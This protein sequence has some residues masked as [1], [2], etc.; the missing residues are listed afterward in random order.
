MATI[1]CLLAL[2][3]S[4][5]ASPRPLR[6]Q[7]GVNIHFTGAPERD[8]DLIAEA[9]FG[10]VR[11]DLFWQRIE[12]S[13]GEYRFEPYDQL[14]DGLD[15]RGIRAMMILDYSNPLY[16]EGHSVRTQAGRE[17]F[18]RF[19]AVAAKR[20]RGRGVRWEIWN[21]P[22]LETYWSPQPS[23]PDYVAL[24]RTTAA[25][26]RAADPQATIVAPATSGFPWEFLEQLFEAGLLEEIDEVSVHPYRGAPP[27]AATEDY[28]RL[29]RMMAQHLTGDRPAPPII[30][31]EWGYATAGA[32]RVS[33]DQQARYLARQYLSNAA[34]GVELSIWYD[35]IDGG[36]DPATRQQRYGTVDRDHRPK[37]AFLAARAL[38]SIL[39]DAHFAR[40]LGGGGEDHILLFSR[41]PAGPLFVAAWTQGAAHE[42]L[43]QGNLRDG[44]V[45]VLDLFGNPV[46]L[47]AKAGAVD[48]PL[49]ESPLYLELPA[50][51]L[52]DSLV[53]HSIE[54]SPLADR[55]VVD[56]R[57]G[58]AGQVAGRLSVRT[59]GRTARESVTLDSTRSA[60]V[61]FPVRWPARRPAAVEVSVAG[62]DGRSLASRRS[63]AYALP[64]P[65]R[66]WGGGPDSAA[67]PLL[68]RLDGDAAVAGTAEVRSGPAD[69][70]G[71]LPLGPTVS[72]SYR[73]A[74]GWKFVRVVAAGQYGIHGRPRA[75][76]VWVRGDGS[77]AALRCRFR[78]VTGETFQPAGEAISW[79]GWRRVALPLDGASASFWGGD[80]DGELDYPIAWDSLLLVDPSPTGGEGELRFA[81]PLLIY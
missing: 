77:G 24:V 2:P 65:F 43:L 59:A 61:E 20:Y 33:T 40:R 58:G 18:A 13:R 8:L 15:Q 73:F 26:I 55:L 80:G 16:E 34:A 57:R 32:G 46:R 17:A 36:A 70:E 37:P 11:V 9:G 44:A 53:V 31:G 41:A 1:L 63:Q 38:T 79:T 6:Q 39:G 30:S 64:V 56:L 28:E 45:R 68:S 48:L 62:P 47:T 67:T 5:G 7:V 27:E 54:L 23:A 75:L 42:V 29:R 72:L 51:T 66:D 78:D 60:R 52:A 35:W 76:S 71:A 12:R 81:S 19:A 74:A 69:H 10:W 49:S 50:D 22:N 21:E 3:A 25:A 4:P 14:L